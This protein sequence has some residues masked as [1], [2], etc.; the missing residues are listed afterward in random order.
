MKYLIVANGYFLPRSIILELA[1][2]RQIIALDGAADRL[3]LLGILPQVILGDFDSVKKNNVWG[4]QNTFDKIDQNSTPYPGKYG[5][6]IVPAK[7]QDYTDL[8]K[9]IK[10]CDQHGATQIDIVCAVGVDRLDHTLGNS[11]ALRTQYKPSRPIF[12]HGE[13]Q[14][15]SF[16][17]NETVIMHGEADEHCGILAFPEAVFTSQGL[18]YNGDSFPLKFAFS[19]STC[20]QLTGKSATIKVKGE[21]LIAHPPMTAAHR[22]FSQ[23]SHFERMEILL[24]EQS[25]ELIEIQVKDLRKFN[26]AES[27]ENLFNSYF[28]Y[29]I[30]YPKDKIMDETLPLNEWVL[31][32]KSPNNPGMN[33]FFSNHEKNNH[34]EK[35]TSTPQFISKL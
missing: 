29:C 11:R 17:K 6:K 1:Q 30:N 23:K 10:Y 32:S 25:R 28:I 14:S 20:N 3:A 24:R 34:N 15:L 13:M 16:C 4:I 35:F 27:G 19:E 5:T 31:I 26:T 8:V 21:A 18:K 22:L 7:D 33:R 12:L 2:Q 9:A